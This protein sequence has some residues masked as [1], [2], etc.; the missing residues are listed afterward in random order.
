MV[1]WRAEQETALKVAEKLSAELPSSTRQGWKG[2]E[3]EE[4][5]REKYC[6]Q[7]PGKEGTSFNGTEIG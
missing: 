1:R 4:E 7:S 5:V 2:G 3:R 6:R